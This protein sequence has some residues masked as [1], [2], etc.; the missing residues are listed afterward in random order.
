MSRLLKLNMARLARQLYFVAGCVLAFGMTLMFSIYGSQTE[1][2][3]VKNINDSM[4]LISVALLVF[5]STFSILFINVE[6]SDGVIRNK[7][8]AGFSQ[9]QVYVSHLLCQYAAVLIMILCWFAG[10]MAA[11]ARLTSELVEYIFIF[12]AF[13]LSYVSILVLMGM[14]IQKKTR[15][16]VFGI[17][18][19]YVLFNAMLVG[20][21]IV[22]FTDG[23]LHKI[24]L[25][26]YHLSPLGT[27]F[28]RS[29]VG[30]EYRLPLVSELLIHTAWIVL[31][32]LL[33]TAKIN[34][35]SLS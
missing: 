14:R 24:A 8:I 31:L 5:F 26:V 33:G 35:R 13:S 1:G 9:K 2:F 21:A 27:W 28:S 22:A 12:A 3:R 23:I 29:Y 25:V 15:A 16:G 6:Y 11:G 20:N 10:G 34:K 32:Y 17:V 4:I 7:I 18:L 30:R 19:I